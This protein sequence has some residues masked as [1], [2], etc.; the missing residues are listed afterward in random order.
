MTATTA[1]PAETYVSRRRRSLVQHA[2][3]RGATAMPLGVVG[4][5][6]LGWTSDAPTDA[7]H[8]EQTTFVALFIG[9]VVTPS[10]AAALAAARYERPSGSLITVLLRSIGIPALAGLSWALLGAV[11][12]LLIAPLTT[13]G[14]SFPGFPLISSAIGLG[15]GAV[16]G[17]LTLLVRLVRTSRATDD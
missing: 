4:G 5:A 11:I 13:L 17:L 14:F 6:V 16:V 12:A 2:F 1:V 3:V 9:F 15:A 10:I 8:L 7:M